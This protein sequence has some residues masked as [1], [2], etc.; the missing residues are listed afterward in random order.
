MKATIM[1]ITL[2]GRKPITD[3]GRKHQPTSIPQWV[4]T[5]CLFRK[6]GRQ[7]YNT[8]QHWWGCHGGGLDAANAL[9]LADR[10]D[11]ALAAG[12]LD[13]LLAKAIAFLQGVDIRAVPLPTYTNPCRHM[14]ESVLPFLRNCGGFD[15]FDTLAQPRVRPNLHGGR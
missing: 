6:L 13:S 11:A 4:D 10:I 15:I 3:A 8:C 9:A 14:M 1:T 2:C 7:Q 12:R 5:V